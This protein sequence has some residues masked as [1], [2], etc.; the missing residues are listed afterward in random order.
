VQR[1]AIFAGTSVLQLVFLEPSELPESQRYM[2][3]GT[4]ICNGIQKY[5]VLCKRLYEKVFFAF[6]TVM[7]GIIAPQEYV[8]DVVAPQILQN[9]QMTMSELLT[10]Y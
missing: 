4:S 3:R 7:E 2:W 1:P 5:E 6:P 8:E 9:G 10:K